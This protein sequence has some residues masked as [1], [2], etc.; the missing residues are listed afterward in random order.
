MSIR[1]MQKENETQ[2]LKEQCDVSS[3][4]RSRMLEGKAK[5]WTKAQYISQEMFATNSTYILAKNNFK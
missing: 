2:N 1:P 3:T 5:C 4:I